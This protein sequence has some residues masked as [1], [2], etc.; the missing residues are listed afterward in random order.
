MEKKTA[1]RRVNV[2]RK[3]RTERTIEIVNVWMEGNKGENGD[4][5][6]PRINNKR[7]NTT[8]RLNE[9]IADETKKRSD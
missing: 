7:K 8:V 4:V 3:R 9:R 5:N 6:W 2:T 1:T